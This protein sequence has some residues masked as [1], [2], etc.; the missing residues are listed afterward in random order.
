MAAGIAAPFA[1]IAAAAAAAVVASW[2]EEG[3]TADAE[4][5]VRMVH[6]TSLEEEG[7]VDRDNHHRRAAFQEEEEEDPI[8]WAVAAF[9]A[10]A[11]EGRSAHHIVSALYMIDRG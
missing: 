8:D 11:A 3:P 4:L 5:V 7:V 10:A 2:E 6:C 1:G 9:S